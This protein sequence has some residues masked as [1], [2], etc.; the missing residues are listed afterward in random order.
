[1]VG[2]CCE[3]LATARVHMHRIRVLPDRGSIVLER[4]A[5]DG[6][7]QGTSRRGERDSELGRARDPWVDPSSPAQGL[8]RQHRDREGRVHGDACGEGNRCE[9]EWRFGGAAV[10]AGVE[11]VLAA[12]LEVVV[13]GT[14]DPLQSLDST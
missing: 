9:V 13:V 3:R 4:D 12:V 2:W 1:M 11:V 8:L 10:V 5:L 14:E 6:F 7:E